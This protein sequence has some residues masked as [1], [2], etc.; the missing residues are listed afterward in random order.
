MVEA[1]QHLDGKRATPTSSGKGEHRGESLAEMVEIKE[2]PFV[3]VMNLIARV[4]DNITA[5]LQ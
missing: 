1:V 4:A 5:H 2:A 3:F